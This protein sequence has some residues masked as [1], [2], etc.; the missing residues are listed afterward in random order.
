MENSRKALAYHRLKACTK[1]INQA[2]GDATSDM[3]LTLATLKILE[4][5][6]SSWQG[7]YTDLPSKQ[8]K[9]PALNKSAIEC[10]DDETRALKP[11][12][13]QNEIDSFVSQYPRSRCFVRPSGTEDV[14]RV[15]AEAE[16]AE[17]AAAVAQ[18]AVDAINTHV[19]NYSSS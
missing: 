7:I 12:A 10:S 18:M 13:L 6:L 5:D 2:V 9:V 14:V 3:L 11:E 15:Y 16:T 19:E 4:L 1:V 8:V 17:G